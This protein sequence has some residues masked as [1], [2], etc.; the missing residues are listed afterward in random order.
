VICM[1]S[2]VGTGRARAYE[3]H[4]QRNREVWIQDP[5]CAAGVL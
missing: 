5:G 2:G 4:D 3:A 1:K